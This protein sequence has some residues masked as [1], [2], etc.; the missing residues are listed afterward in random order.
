MKI[1][2]HDKPFG[3]VTSISGLSISIEI[4]NQL[5]EN[6]LEIEVVSGDS[7]KK[8]YAGTVGDIFLIG[9]TSTHDTIHYGLFEEVKLVS[10]INA[11]GTPGKRK[12][13]IIAKVIGYQNKKVKDKLKFDRGIGHYPRFNS[14]CY[15][16]TTEEKQSLFFVVGDRRN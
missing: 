8:N 4:D 7:P 14:K 5:L 1:E 12:A 16:L 3:Q 6:N 10:T 9:G 13:I 11:D 2:L 15:L